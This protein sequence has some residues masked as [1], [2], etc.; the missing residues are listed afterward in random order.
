[1]SS[2]VLFYHDESVPPR[3]AGAALEECPD[4]RGCL[5]RLV[6]QWVVLP[7]EWDELPAD[8][9]TD[10]LHPSGGDVLDKLVENHLLTRFQ[11]DKVREGG[12]SELVLGHY[13]LLDVIGRGGMGTV[14]RA[15]HLH[16][17]R[18]VAVK[19]MA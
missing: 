4:A 17:R 2:S 6:E 11:A 5:T 18:Q 10:I 15:E 7:E 1:M 16:L 14:Y 19:V 12:E 8:L 13:R 9:R 3:P